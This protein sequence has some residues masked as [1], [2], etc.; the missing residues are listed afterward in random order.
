MDF[1]QQRLYLRKVADAVTIEEIC[2]IVSRSVFS[3][4]VRLP[5]HAVSVHLRLHRTIPIWEFLN[6]L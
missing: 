6:K 3:A 4:A 1:L 2:V 5:L